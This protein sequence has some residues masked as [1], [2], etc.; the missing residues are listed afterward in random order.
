MATININNSTVIINN[1]YQSNLLTLIAEIPLTNSDQKAI[2]D[3]KYLSEVNKYSWSLVPKGYVQSSKGFLHRF[4]LNIEN[5]LIPGLDIDHIDRNRLNNRSSNLRIC[6]KLENN[7][8]RTK[9]KN[10]SSIFIGVAW[11]KRDKKW[12]GQIGHQNKTINLGYFDDEI[13]AAQTYDEA[14]AN[15]PIDETFKQYNFTQ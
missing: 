8:N 10:K 11:V 15:I 2:I 13:E 1:Y 9:S 3:A 7:R 6:T 5:K 4:I 12:R 14:L